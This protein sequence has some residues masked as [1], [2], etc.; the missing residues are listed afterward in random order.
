MTHTYFQRSSTWLIAFFFLVCGISVGAFTELSL[1]DESRAQ[2]GAY[3]MEH[4]FSD[5]TALDHSAVL[6][7]SAGNNLGLLLLVFLSGLIPLGFPAA[8][9]VIAYKG[10]ALG[11]SAA[12]LLE[13]LQFKGAVTLFLTVLPPNLLILPALFLAVAAA[14]N[15]SAG[16]RGN[17]RKKSLS[18]EAGPYCACFVPPLL[19]ASAAALIEA[20]ICPALLQLIK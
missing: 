15:T 11:F 6:L 20:F 18:Q 9:A 19:L 13:F 3:L 5:N 16:R 14:I 8:Y 4:L 1:P 7:Q 2:V 10:A 17:H 12:L